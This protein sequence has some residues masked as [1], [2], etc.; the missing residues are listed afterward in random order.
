M[1]THLFTEVEKEKKTTQNNF[2]MN[3][4]SIIEIRYYTN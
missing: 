2:E 1:N 4:I 3:C